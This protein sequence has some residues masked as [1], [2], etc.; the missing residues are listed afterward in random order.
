MRQGVT[1]FL[2]VL[3]VAFAA[4]AITRVL[5]IHDARDLWATGRTT[6]G[7]VVDFG[8]RRKSNLR[9]YSYTYRVEGREYRRERRAIATSAGEFLVG[10]AVEVRYDPADPVR[11]LTPAERVEQEEWANRVIFPVISAAFFAWAIARMRGG[12]GKRAT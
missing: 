1:V 10:S 9:E 3:A 11:S 6:E 12:R 2:F 5:L 7:T 4:L 8:T